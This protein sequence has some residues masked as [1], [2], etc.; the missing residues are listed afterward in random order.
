MNCIDNIKELHAEIEKYGGKKAKRD[1]YTTVASEFNVSVSTVRS[2][3]F[4]RFEIPLG[5]YGFNVHPRLVRIMQNHLQNIRKQNS[6][7]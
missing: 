1:L 5:P 2:H 6:A 7:V 4:S 3:W